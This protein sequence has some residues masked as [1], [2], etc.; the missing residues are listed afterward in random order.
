MR[1]LRS[2]GRGKEGLRI[3]AQEKPGFCTLCR[4]RCGTINVVEN[5]RLVAVRPNPAHP[6]GKAIC[7]KGRA[8]PE[9][10]HSARRLKTPLRRTSP[11]GAADPG[12][13]PISWDEALTEIA[14]RLGR[15]REETGPESVA[16][17]VTSGS[18]SS[19]S[20]SLDW[21]QRFIR[22]FGSPNNC[23][24]TEVCN[25]HKD[26]AHAFT[27]G[28]GLPTADYR[29]SE[30]ILL[31]GHNPANVWLAQAEAISAARARGA[32]LA[33]IDPRRTGSARD[34]DL[35]L[36]IRPGTDAALALGLARWLIVNRAYDADFV[37]HWTKASPTNK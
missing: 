11:K 1:C 33:V 7:P 5:D 17:A 26:H 18:S 13:V 3:S 31:W 36:R 23:F 6:T 15:Y 32:R 27:F 19:T 29:N 2:E 25:W 37:R 24:S 4:S 20:D 21:I 9:I 10:A 22:G 14:E 35:W 28:C 8:A 16:F 34:A 12:F 30:L